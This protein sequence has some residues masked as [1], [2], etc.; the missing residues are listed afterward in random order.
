MHQT[1]F[2]PAMIETFR[3]CKHAYEL[4]FLKGFFPSS[5][6][7]LNV[8]SKHFILRTLAQINRGR[9]TTVNQVQKY[10]GQ[11]WPVEMVS[12]CT[13][14]KESATQSFLFA[15]KTL[16]HYV[17]KPYFPSGAQIV[18]SALKV[19]ARVPHVRVYLEDTLDLVLWYPQEKKLELI[20]FRVRPIKSSDPAWPSASTLVKKFLA[21]RLKTRWP[22]EKLS[23]TLLKIGP[24][25]FSQMELALEESTYRLHWRELIDNL[26][27]MKTFAGHET[28]GY[29]LTPPN[30]C[31]Y[32]QL[33]TTRLGNVGEVESAPI[34]KTA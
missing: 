16:L 11:N 34:S 20:D 19:R 31:K 8:I 5:P 26:E 3:A 28:A 15:Y 25:G 32:C 2:S 7:S 18:G 24:Q 12:Q 9:L 27:A 33:L 30:D 17:E 23:L 29:C 13:K 4:V 10:I 21:E 6:E 1:L 14:D 22:F